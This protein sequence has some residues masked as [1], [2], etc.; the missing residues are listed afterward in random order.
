MSCFQKQ[1]VLHKLPLPVDVLHIV[2]DYCFKYITD[3]Q[4]EKKASLLNVIEK[5][6][7][8]RHISKIPGLWF[9]EHDHQHAFVKTKCFA[10]YSINVAKENWSPGSVYQPETYLS[11]NM[12]SKCGEFVNPK[13]KACNKN[14]ATR[15]QCKRQFHRHED[16]PFSKVLCKE[17]KYHLS[18][19]LP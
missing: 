11:F 9:R 13:T 16:N 12:C 14:P 18:Y 1:L 19:L 3:V 10:I 7:E 2:Y 8:I 15:D 4:K 17:E 6:T 5:Q